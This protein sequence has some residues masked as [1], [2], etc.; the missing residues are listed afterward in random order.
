MLESTNGQH[1]TDAEA[2]TLMLIANSHTY[3]DT[4][5]ANKTRASA[6]GKQC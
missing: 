3:H 6:M 1:I 4:R 5:F 2:D